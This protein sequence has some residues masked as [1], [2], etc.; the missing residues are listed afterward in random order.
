MWADRRRRNGP[1]R[2]S[3][4]GTDRSCLRQYR[5]CGSRL[6]HRRSNCRTPNTICI[7]PCKNLQR[8]K[9]YTLWNRP[10]QE[11]QAG[12]GRRGLRGASWQE[13]ASSGRLRWRVEQYLGSL[14]LGAGDG[15]GYRWTAVFSFFSCLFEGGNGGGSGHWRES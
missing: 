7:P 1:C 9:R 15:A 3:N 6:R 12:R 2:V 14:L 11:K 5:V 13:A 4:P 8:S 10:P